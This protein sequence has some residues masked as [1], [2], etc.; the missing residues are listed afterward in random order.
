MLYLL[1]SPLNASTAA[2]FM[3]ATS[4][5]RYHPAQRVRSSATNAEPLSSDDSTA[6][7]QAED[8]NAHGAGGWHTQL[9]GAGHLPQR[10]ASAPH[11]Q[12]GNGRGM[13]GIGVT[14]IG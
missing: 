2:L 3:V 7:A 14:R 9:P 13:D 1:A 6:E 12:E 11:R 10:I 8:L 5:A 4:G